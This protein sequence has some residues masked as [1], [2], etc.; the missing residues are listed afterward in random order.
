MSVESFLDTNV[1]VYQPEHS[2]VNK[3]DIAEGTAQSSAYISSQVV[4]ELLKMVLCK[5]RVKL[6][7]DDAPLS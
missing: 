1:F 6:A 2:D 5:A 3:A 4:K 7:P